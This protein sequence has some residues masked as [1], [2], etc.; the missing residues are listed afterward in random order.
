[1]ARLFTVQ[2]AKHLFALSTDYV[3]QITGLEER[4]NV[5]SSDAKEAVLKIEAKGTFSCLAAREFESRIL[6]GYSPDEE[7]KD[8]LLKIYRYQYAQNNL[9]PYWEILDQAEYMRVALDDLSIGLGMISWLLAGRQAREQAEKSYR[10]LFDLNRR[11]I[12]NKLA[13]CK[14][15]LD[16]VGYFT[17][18]N[19]LIFYKNGPDAFREYIEGAFSDQSSMSQIRD[20]K[21][22]IEHAQRLLD[23]MYAAKALCQRYDGDASAK[24]HLAAASKLFQNRAEKEIIKHAGLQQDYIEEEQVLISSIYQ[25]RSADEITQKLPVSYSESEDIQ[26][27]I[28]RLL[29]QS[30]CLSWYFAS[31]DTKRE[32]FTLCQ[33]LDALPYQEREV[34][35]QTVSELKSLPSISRE[36]A[37]EHFAEHPDVY[38][39]ELQLRYPATA[40]SLLGIDG[41]RKAKDDIDETLD[42]LQGTIS[43][44]EKLQDGIRDIIRKS[45]VPE[46]L[47][48]LRGIPVEELN[49]DKRGIRTKT[50]RD[51]GYENIAD[52]YTA[53]KW[54]LESIAG[55]SGEGADQIKADAEY[56]AQE[57]KKGLK[58]RLSLDDR[59]PEAEEILRSIYPYLTVRKDY[60]EL[61]DQYHRLET[62]YKE[63]F[64]PFAKVKDCVNW[65]CL[66]KDEKTELIDSYIGMKDL[67]AQHDMP[68]IFALVARILGTLQNLNA[69]DVLIWEDFEKRS[70]EYFQVV[71]EL[72][73][74]LGNGDVLYGLPEELARE[75]QDECFF[76]DGLECTL[77]KY[78]EMGVKYVLHQKNVL[79]GDEMGLGKTIQAIASMVSL[80][81]VGATHFVV[82]CPASVLPNWCKE[83]STKS[84]LHVVKV[85]GPSCLEA[86]DSWK[87]NGGVAV[88]TFETTGH[89]ALEEDFRFTL[90]IVD[91]AHY[92]KNPQ[93]ARTVNVKNLSTHADRM[94]FMTGTAL[95][96]KVDEMLSLLEILNPSA[97]KKARTM[98]FLSTAPQFR[99]RIA[100]VYYRRKRDDVLSELPELMESIEWC[101][102]SPK[103]AMIYEADVCAKNYANIR[104]LSWN[105]SNDL[106]GSCKAQ[107][108]LELINEAEE[109]GRKI[110]VFSFFLDTIRKICNLLG[111][112]CMPPI[113]GS[114]PPARRQ[115]ILDEF[116]RAPAGTVLPAQ[117]QAG[118]TGLNIQSASVIIFCEPQLKPSLETQA[119]S[120]AY[121]MG[122]TRNVLVY[123]LLC[124]DT[125]D[126]K[127]M[128][129]LEKKQNIF[130]AF[131]D[132]SVA[133]AESMDS[134]DDKTFGEIIQEEIERI[135]ESQ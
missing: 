17:P 50:L 2:E 24:V 108:M 97:A 65:F 111:N 42:N 34:Y 3:N 12:G 32:V 122:Q 128:E 11:Q 8:M 23:T 123:R 77:R 70:I 26:K 117:I 29:S 81:N 37:M 48:I 52:V 38:A 84:K 57:S 41:I 101:E 99:E 31:P 47:N 74:E 102:L 80:K 58:L 110:I 124:Q 56:I 69:E 66:T 121:R 83:I 105:V 22:T 5:L 44:L 10:Y 73:P 45:L 125:V 94:L 4:L 43:Q 82:V 53:T 118:G 67:L 89:F 88:T 130:D 113:N 60:L 46:L 27:K 15:I 133:A 55:I 115:E 64:R 92:I 59:T 49:R 16:V 63:L 40:P 127:V 90:L 106:K 87:K 79:L 112:R 18:E 76:P 28:A 132:T 7:E 1:M 93:A 20:V 107:R 54:E 104:Q 68:K 19:G 129:R 100:E 30:S 6:E 98:S 114:V 71:E 78:Q 21:Q 75:I 126:E 91:E 134:M 36:E 9:F 103:E 72:L 61:S 119:I 14:R 62:K 33:Q 25:Y 116:E 96:N 95:E 51:Y 13:E 131:A 35:E 135:R 39:Y 109:D 120:R 86:L 85:H